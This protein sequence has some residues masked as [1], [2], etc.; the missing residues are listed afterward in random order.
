M[1]YKVGQTLWFERTL[2]AK[3]GSGEDLVVTKV[4]RKWVSL[5]RARFP[6]HNVY[7]VPVD[8]NYV[9]GGE[10]SSPGRVWASK[11]EAEAHQE[12]R[13]EWAA[14]LRE[15]AYAQPPKGMTK[16]EIARLRA[17]LKG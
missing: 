4:A 1:E 7:R 15:A 10:Y 9:D 11:E 16:E 14:F 13:S 17:M 2:N 8:C 3:P 5:A 12:L 6:N